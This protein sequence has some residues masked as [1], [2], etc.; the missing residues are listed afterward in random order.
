MDN[1]DG[2][3]QDTDLF[4]S[5][6]HFLSVRCTCFI[7]GLITGLNSVIKKTHKGCIEIKALKIH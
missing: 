1:S 5:L 2:K 6:V 3:A 7:V 4:S